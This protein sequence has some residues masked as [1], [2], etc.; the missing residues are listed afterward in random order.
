MTDTTISKFAKVTFVVLLILFIFREGS[1]LALNRIKDLMINN[2]FIV[3]IFIVIILIWLNK[4]G[5]KK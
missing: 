5:G 4:T 1:L 2:I 3:L